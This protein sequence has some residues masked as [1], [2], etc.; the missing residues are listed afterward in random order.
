MQLV[1]RLGNSI[2]IVKNRCPLLQ[3]D[4]VGRSHKTS[5]WGGCV[6]SLHLYLPIYFPRGNAPQVWR[7][8]YAYGEEFAPKTD[9]VATSQAAKY[10]CCCTT[11]YWWP[12]NRCNTVHANKMFVIAI[13]HRGQVA[14]IKTVAGSIIKSCCPPTPVAY[15]TPF[16]LYWLRQ[17]NSVGV[18]PNTNG[19]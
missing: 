11:P 16:D 14:K 7:H 2:G 12:V 1:P 5:Y 19:G 13:L 17:F 8:P 4:G 9:I 10:V 3:T 18:G 15:E 6:E